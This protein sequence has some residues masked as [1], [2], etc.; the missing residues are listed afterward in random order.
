MEDSARFS[1]NTAEL[2]QK[3]AAFDHIKNVASA[4]GRSFE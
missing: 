3:L 2:E 1:L 4:M